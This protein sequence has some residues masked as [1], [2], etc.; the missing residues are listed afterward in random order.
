MKL[1]FASL[2]L[3]LAA[4][5]ASLGKASPDD[6]TLSLVLRSAPFI[7]FAKQAPSTLPE[8]NVDTDFNYYFFS[9]MMYEASGIPPSFLAA[10]DRNAKTDFPEDFEQY[11]RDD[12]EVCTS[13]FAPDV[14]VI[15]EPWITPATTTILETRKTCIVDENDHVL[16]MLG[17]F[18]FHDDIELGITSFRAIPSLPDALEPLR[19]IPTTW[20]A[21]A[22]QQL[23]FSV[24]L[25]SDSQLKDLLAQNSLAELDFVSDEDLAAAMEQ[26]DGAAAFDKEYQTFHVGG[27]DYRLWI[28]SVQLKKDEAV[29]A[30][31]YRPRNAPMPKLVKKS[32]AL[33]MKP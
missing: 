33:S 9:D 3:V 19:H 18:N 5:K 23:P 17:C 6:E 22:F 7:I 31:A 16:Y 14:K 13:F 24:R 2:A 26:V 29:W 1:Q 11:F 30:V 25:Y 12:A 27:S 8:Y 10:G 21:Q 28:W 32:I 4:S 15:T 20:Y